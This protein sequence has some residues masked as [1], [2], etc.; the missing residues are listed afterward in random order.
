M[1]FSRFVQD[2]LLERLSDE[3]VLTVHDS[4]E[5]YRQLCA[6][7][8]GD[9]IVF[10]DATDITAFEARQHAVAAW[11][12]L[13]EDSDKKLLIYR[14]TEQ[15]EQAG[16]LLDPL[17][18]FAAIGGVFP[19]PG[20]AGEGYRDLAIGAFPHLRSDIDGLFANGEPE[21]QTLDS[22][23]SGDTWPTLSAA[24]G[25]RDHVSIIVSLLDESQNVAD[26]VFGS[27]AAHSELAGFLASTLEIPESEVP[28]N[29][30][31]FRNTIWRKLLVSEFAF[32][33][34]EPFPAD[35]K[36][37]PRCREESRGF[38]TRVCSQL[39]KSATDVYAE[40]ALRIEQELDLVQYVSSTSTC[41]TVDTFAA[42][43]AFILKEAA[44]ALETDQIE[45]ARELVDRGTE[46]FWYKQYGSLKG[47][48]EIVVAAIDT[49]EA[50]EKAAVPTGNSDL[51]EWYQS[52]GTSVDRSYRSFAFTFA[53][54]SDEE[55]WGISLMGL[56]DHV[57]ARYRSWADNV[58]QVL[59]SQIRDAGWPLPGL[60]KQS[61]VFHSVVEPH[62]AQGKRV[63]YFLVDALRFELGESVTA[64][65]EAKGVKTELK[66][67]G[68]LLPTKTTLG[69]S[70]L[71]PA[72]NEP[73]SVSV[74][75]GKWTV[76]RG[77][78]PITSAADRDERFR[79]Y[80]G[81]Q[82]LVER[83]DKWKKRRKGSGSPDKRNQLAVIRSTDIDQAGEANDALF[84]AALE[85]VVNELIAGITKA[86]DLGFELAVVA[87][88]HGFL[89]LP[90]RSFG[91]EVT[92][93]A[94]D[95]RVRH[96]R[97]AFG[98]IEKAD[99]LIVLDEARLGYKVDG[100]SLALPASLGSFS[101]PGEYTHGGLS[102]QESLVPVITVTPGAETTASQRKPLPV[103]LSYRGNKSATISNRVPH[104]TVTV[105]GD[106]A[107]T[108][109]FE[110]EW[111]QRSA[112]IFIRVEDREGKVCGKVPPNSFLDADTA[113]L[114]IPDGTT[115]RIPVTIDE[116][117]EGTVTVRA[118]DATSN[119]TLDTVE[120]Q[121]NTLF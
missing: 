105:G 48:W 36:S 101:R 98:R 99:H 23:G 26:E 41:G 52:A 30:Q 110:E 10:V 64:K 46:Q 111:A 81:D 12:H 92:H 103:S 56:A 80:K 94:G 24:I 6:E 66:P 60:L 109:D 114:S 47:P 13:K 77:S 84:R 70:A 79:E 42:E 100:L 54:L 85:N 65:L 116:E 37:V 32:D 117:F 82:C 8:A 118:M 38:V 57:T 72:G 90:E 39:R 51:V 53:Q 108:L 49:I 112:D 45:K 14:N 83:L 34:D 19:K 33:M 62:L 87:A 119:K 86:F 59:V 15:P 75:D 20:Q 73:L 68:T 120:L 5:R 67:A 107:N 96:E 91:D 25:S 69:M 113:A 7:L 115:T 27:S 29:A 11:E 35:L 18:A 50:T 31:D 4:K 22:L 121:L 44:N 76:Y 28:D 17:A 93:P 102:L 88:D 2:R 97:Y 74:Q 78:R 43:N 16:Q 40:H 58:Q 95:I 104:I 89:Y 71:G 3:R 55:P 21:V 1:S 61:D 106:R 9:T 63:A